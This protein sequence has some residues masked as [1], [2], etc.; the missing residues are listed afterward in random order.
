[1]IGK[2][3]DNNLA[4]LWRFQLHHLRQLCSGIQVYCILVKLAPVS[5]SN[6]I[7]TGR[8]SFWRNYFRPTPVSLWRS[9]LGPMGVSIH[10]Y[11]RSDDLLANRAT[12]SMVF[13]CVADKSGLLLCQGQGCFLTSFYYLNVCVFRVT[14]T[15]TNLFMVRWGFVYD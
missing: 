1:M 3:K 4:L 11:T 6:I 2:K 8:L 10:C 14:Q 15:N 12:G 9:D 7:I 5:D 13:L